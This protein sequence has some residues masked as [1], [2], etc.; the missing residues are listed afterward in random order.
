MDVQAVRTRAGT[1][2]A[3]MVVIAVAVALTGCDRGRRLDQLTP[4]APAATPFLLGVTAEP[5]GS[6]VT[7]ESA[8]SLPT[9]DPALTAWTV[10]LYAGGDN[11]RDEAAWN[12]LNA[13]EAAVSSE[14]VTVVAQVD[15]QDEGRTGTRS[16]V[17]YR[18]QPDA[19]RSQLSSP[20]LIDLGEINGGDPNTLADFLAWAT[21]N[22][23]AQRYLL[24][25]GDFGGGWYGC[26]L[27]TDVGFANEIDHL[28]L[29]DIDQ[30]LSLAQAQNPAARLDLLAFNASFM[31]Q[32]DV[33]QM[34]QSYAD[35]AVAAPGP[36]PLAGWDYG[37]LLA[38]LAKDPGLDTGDLAGALAAQFDDPQRLNERDPAAMTAIDLSQL[39]AVTAALDALIAA[40]DAEPVIGSRIAADARRGALAYG[41]EIVSHDSKL[42]A[43]DL[44]H[45][46]ALL[47]AL[48]PGSD[49]GVAG[50]ALAAAVENATIATG[51][52]DEDGRGLAIYWPAAPNDLDE[53]YASVSRLPAWAGYLS[54]FVE[55]SGAVEA[56]IVAVENSG[57][58]PVNLAQPALLRA[59]MIGSEIRDVAIVAAQET[60]DG[61]WVLRQME[62]IPAPANELAG[63]VATQAWP[64]GR[65]ESLLVWDT[66]SGFLSDH[67]GAGD[68]TVLQPVASGGAGPALVAQGEMSPEPVGAGAT[69]NLVFSPDGS[70]P[71]QVW[72][73]VSAGESGLLVGESRPLPGTSFQSSALILSSDGALV[74]E[75]AATLTFDEN[76]NLFRQ[77]RPLPD[78]SYA[79]GILAT[80]IHGQ[81]SM[82]ST[83]LNVN[84]SAVAGGYRAFVD[85]QYGLQFPYPA[86][87]LPPVVQ[88]DIV[89]TRNVSGTAEMQIRVFPGWTGDPA[90]LHA[91]VIATFGDVSPLLQDTRPVGETGIEAIRTAYG[92]ASETDGPRTGILL[93]FIDED[94]GYAIDLDGPQASEA[95]SLATV[96][97]VADGWSRLPERL[98]FGPVPASDRSVD[99]LT[100]RIPASFAYQEQ[101]R[102]NRFAEQPNTF[103]AVRTQPA[104]RSASEGLVSLLQTAATGLDSFT[105][106]EPQRRYL[107]GRI[108]E[109]NQLSYVDS[110]GEPIEG[111]LLITVDAGREIAVWAEAPESYQPDF[112]EHVV[113]PAVAS[114]RLIP[115]S[116]P[117]G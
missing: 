18:L 104:S 54:Q 20:G 77:A 101:N 65:H 61:R 16:G 106:N 5:V 49:I 109:S 79:A 64:D 108:W 117:Q 114:I 14:Q 115:G 72:A 100:L 67:T 38:T 21:E 3:L 28:T 45:A 13:I 62:P 74:T 37:A 92:Y 22:F 71:R 47:A 75:P 70:E 107:A 15:W 29:G 24:F 88:G 6:I 26:C 113:M 55:A 36:V 30:A 85:A 116:A 9:P 80:T 31:S 69:A 19:D 95:V 59:E 94:A 81:A 32:L 40:L 1:A 27:D 90:S 25:I 2:G 93:T 23:P 87:W 78:G 84:S 48:A 39:P 66:I 76:G 58:D 68:F 103:I 89:H 34:A 57:R 60:A 41:G 111:L 56:P 112:F 33:H 12:A 44:H 73:V 46:G 105:A 7:V 82:A 17:R 35:F 91:E 52:G 86:D 50:A 8:P 11:G 96:D 10:M 110:A 43:V 63:G 83:P 4:E 53:A 42:A 51:P 102:W 99:E 98:G 97:A